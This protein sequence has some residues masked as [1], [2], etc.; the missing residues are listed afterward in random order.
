M[1][2]AQSYHSA[3]LAGVSITSRKHP[4][5][6]RYRAAAHGDG[7]VVLLDGTHLV[8]DALRSGI[9]ITHVAITTAAHERPDVR[10]LVADLAR[11][12]TETATVSAA[13]MDAI[14]PV[15]TSTGIVALAARPAH[16]SDHL[17]RGSTSLVV[18]AV[19]VQDP[20]NL[21]AIARVTESAGA[22]GM[23]AA[24]ESADPFGWKALRGSMGSG[25]R[26]PIVRGATHVAIADARRHGCRVVAAMPRDGEPIYDADLA[27]PLAVLLGGEGHGLTPA[28]LESADARLSVPMQ[29]PVESL[30]VAVAAALILYEAR[31]QRTT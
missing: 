13:V 14:S 28:M 16:Q 25:L 4:L 18:I 19:D 26:L 11:A 12:R 23:V 10:H 8:A 15:R 5:V 24:G 22:S 17:F 20:G 29:T 9:A 6:A 31:R 7:D 3:I 2:P 27:G 21:G 1:F 30:N